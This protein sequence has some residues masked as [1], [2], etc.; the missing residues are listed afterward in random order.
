VGARPTRKHGRVDNDQERIPLY[1]LQHFW[2]QSQRVPAFSVGGG[3]F[4]CFQDLISCFS[5]NVQSN[6][7]TSP[8]SQHVMRKKTHQ[9]GTGAEN[10][11]T[12][13]AEKSS[14]RGGPPSMAPH[15]T[16]AANNIYIIPNGTVN[17]EWVWGG[18]GKGGG[19]PR[20]CVRKARHAKPILVHILKMESPTKGALSCSWM[21]FARQME[22]RGTPRAEKPKTIQSRNPDIP[23][24]HLHKAKEEPPLAQLEADAD[25]QRG[26]ILSS[27]IITS[28]RR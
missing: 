22:V 5:R 7:K 25:G 23:S 6:I 13:H 10:P 17:D 14:R 9:I 16:P 12:I 27:I 15:P 3:S 8:P 19:S 24:D 28:L 1:L 20:S 4:L 18:W 11:K 21:T 26:V 2:D